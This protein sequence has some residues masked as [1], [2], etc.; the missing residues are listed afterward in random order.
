MA[1]HSL[2]SPVKH[3][4]ALQAGDRAKSLRQSVDITRLSKIALYNLE[5]EGEGLDY[6]AAEA[7][8]GDI[9][10]ADADAEIDFEELKDDGK[11]GRGSWVL[12]GW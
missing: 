5:K 7:Q 10:I 11:P 3:T 6:A 1:A 9:R 12:M 8:P 2:G 4:M